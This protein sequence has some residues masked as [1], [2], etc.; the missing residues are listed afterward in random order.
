[1]ITQYEVPSLLRKEQVVTNEPL[2]PGNISMDVYKCVH[3]FTEYTRKAVQDH[4]LLVVKKCFR[5]A[6]QLHHYGD[7]VVKMCIENI[8]IYSFS[9][10]LP[11]DRIERLIL[12]SLIPADLNTLYIKQVAASGC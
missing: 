7:A 2:Y 12:Q 6:D 1:M 9:S 10:F 3:S 8:F 4:H 11:K 5:L